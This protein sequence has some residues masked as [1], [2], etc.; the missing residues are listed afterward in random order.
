[1]GEDIDLW[2]RLAATGTCVGFTDARS[3]Y[4]VHDERD[5]A[6]SLDALTKMERDRELVVERFAVSAAPARLVRRARAVTRARTARY[7]LRAE[8][9]RHAR[10]AAIS[11][12]RALPTLEGAATL[13]LAALPAGV[14][15]PLVAARRVGRA[16]GLPLGR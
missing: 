2:L 7:W 9:R 5:R 13:V 15:R 8:Q 4:V 1:G 3:V 10:A 14:R 11:S 12:L 6:R 16:R